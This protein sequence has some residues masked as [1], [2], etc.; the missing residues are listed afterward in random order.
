MCWKVKART[1]TSAYVRCLDH[2][3]Y[4]LKWRRLQRYDNSSLENMLLAFFLSIWITV[5]A[6]WHD[7]ALYIKPKMKSI[8]SWRYWFRKAPWFCTGCSI[9]P[10][11]IIP[12][13]GKFFLIYCHQYHQRI[14]ANFGLLYLT[15]LYSI[16]VKT[17]PWLWTKW[18][19]HWFVLFP[20]LN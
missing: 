17:Y 19:L 7:V 10:I 13:H 3:V 2:S 6:W 9:P 16:N 15:Y 18:W 11:H 5:E 20:T 8:S 4:N 12:I 14:N 1:N